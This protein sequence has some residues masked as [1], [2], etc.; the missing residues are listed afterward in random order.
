MIPE[1]LKTKEGRDKK[2]QELKEKREKT[3]KLK[4]EILTRIE[5]MKEVQKSPK[6][7]QKA[8]EKAK[9]NATDPEA[10]H[11]QM[12][13]KDYAT[14][15]NAQIL[16]ENQIVLTSNISSNPADTN[17]LIP[18]LQKFQDQY[19]IN[20]K[21]LLAD[22]GYASEENY[23]F[24]ETNEIDGYIPSQIDQVNLTDYAYH[25]VSDIYTDAN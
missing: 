23:T 11:M 6:K 21:K 14:G 9:I 19:Q 12:K 15:Y 20:P 1:E 18:T 3:E 8:L 17:E 22:K 7:K 16:T 2:L 5:N 24:L 10:R 25:E 4:Q 13:H